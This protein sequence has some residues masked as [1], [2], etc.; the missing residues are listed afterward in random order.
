MALL[1]LLLRAIGEI[2]TLAEGTDVALR[3]EFLKNILGERALHELYYNEGQ[4]L[5]ILHEQ[6]AVEPTVAPAACARGPVRRSATAAA[7]M[8]RQEA[9]V[10]W[11][12]PSKAGQCQFV[13]S[14]PG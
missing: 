5:T 12:Q 6:L 11:N 3:V 8:R 13:T 14:R 4:V 9:P 1:R 7:A 10:A 2:E